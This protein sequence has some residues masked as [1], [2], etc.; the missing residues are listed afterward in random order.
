[1]LLKQ[2]LKQ[3][4][5]LLLG[6]L[7][8][9]VVVNLCAAPKPSLRVLKFVLNKQPVFYYKKKQNTHFIVTFFL[10]LGE[11]TVYHKQEI[12]I[13][14]INKIV[15]AFKSKVCLLPPA[16]EFGCD[17]LHSLPFFQLCYFLSVM[18]MK[19][20]IFHSPVM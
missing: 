3:K 16:T 14:L 4:L 5:H 1:M 10:S 18:E 20:L 13:C 15:P 7:L 17:V 9:C 8:L 11:R 19:C 12:L 2:F 6:N